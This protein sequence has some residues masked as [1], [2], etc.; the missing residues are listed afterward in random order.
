MGIVN[1]VFL[2]DVTARTSLE[3]QEMRSKGKHE[4]SHGVMEDS[5][6]STVVVQTNITFS[7]FFP[8]IS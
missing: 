3:G 6:E 5:A 4:Q 2:E 1:E 7:Y 8:S